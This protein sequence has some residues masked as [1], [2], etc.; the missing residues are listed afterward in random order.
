MEGYGYIYILKL[1]E[2]VT[3]LNSRKNWSIDLIPKSVKSFDFLAILYRKPREY[4]KPK[5]KIGDSS[6]L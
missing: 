2:I 5:V 4:R 1:C 6:D 3:N